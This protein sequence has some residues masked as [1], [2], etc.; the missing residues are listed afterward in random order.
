MFF[1][2]TTNKNLAKIPNSDLCFLCV[3][4]VT[5]FFKILEISELVI[6][7]T[8]KHVRLHSAWLPEYMS[9]FC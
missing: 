5:G 2:V 6:I 4:N 8:G 7:L 9:K 3:M 1:Y